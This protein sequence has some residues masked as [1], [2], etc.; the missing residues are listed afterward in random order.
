[1]T[2]DG[3]DELL[4]GYSYMWATSDPLEWKKKRDAQAS[5]MTFATDTLAEAIGVKA[6]SPY[7]Q[8]SFIN[9]ALSEADRNACIADLP[10]ELKPSEPSERILHTTGKVCLRLAFPESGSAFRR[11]D[12]IEVGSGC[13]TAHIDEHFRHRVSEEEFQREK[14]RV[15]EQDRVV[16]VSPEHMFYYRIFTE[17]FPNGLDDIDRFGSDPCTGCGYQ[18]RSPEE[19]FCHICGA[20]PARA[21][22]ASNG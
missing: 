20:W 1:M 11:K 4:G 22:I 17:V 14:C 19:N 13:S 18:I 12:P 8:P 16:L 21:P 3:A 15:Y 9:F 6:I 5:R 2:G 7:L 10:M